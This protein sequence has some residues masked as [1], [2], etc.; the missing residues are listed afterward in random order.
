MLDEQSWR[1]DTDQQK[2]IIPSPPFLEG[3]HKII[4][5]LA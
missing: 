3:E 5:T 2:S 1:Y 4:L